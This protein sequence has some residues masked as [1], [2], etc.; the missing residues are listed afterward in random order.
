[1]SISRVFNKWLNKLYKILAILLVVFAVLI[2]SLR[3][4]IPYAHQ[5]R[6]SFQDYINTSYNSN[7]IIGSLN[8]E[9]Q[10]YGPT[11]I[12]ENVN[13]LQTELAEVYIRKIAISI[14]FWAS[15][16]AWE[17]ISYDLNLDGAKVYLDQYVDESDRTDNSKLAIEASLLSNFS[18][19]FLKRISQFSLSN[20]QVIYRTELEEHTFL[21]SQLN[22]NNKENRHLATGDVIV[23]GLSSNNLKLLIDIEGS[24]SQ[25]MNGQIYLQGNELNITPWLDEVFVIE[26]EITHSTINFDAWLSIEDG[27]AKSLQVVL[28]DN[29]ISWQNGDKNQSISMHQGQFFVGGL[30]KSNQLT[31]RST[32]L[33]LKINQDKWQELSIEARKNG[34]EL[35]AYLTYLDLS[36]LKKLFPLFSN[37]EFNSKMVAE[38]ALNGDVKDIYFYKNHQGSKFSATF[39]DVNSQYS[40]GIP[41]LDNVSGSLIYSDNKFQIELAAKDGTLDFDQHFKQALP[42][43]QLSATV[44]AD[45]SERPWRFD[46]TSIS[47]ISDELTLS[48]DIGVKIPENDLV[49]MSLLASV[50]NLNVVNAN[51]YYPYM[52][53]GE[54]LVNYLDGA[55]VKGELSQAQILFHGPLGKFPFKDYSGIFT[56]DAELTDAVFKFASEWPAIN[57]FSANLNFTNNSMLIHGRKGNLSGMRVDGVEA[58]ILELSGDQVLT[59]NVELDE[60]N[61]DHVR[62]LMLSS[63]LADT[64]GKTLTQIAI[65][66]NISGEFNLTLPL[67]SKDGSVAKGFINLNNNNVSLESPQ[68]NFSQVNG[69]LSFNNNVIEVEDLSLHW[70]GLPL[71]VSVKANDEINHY[72]TDITINANWQDDKWHKYVP[73]LLKK[74]VKGTFDWQGDL[75]LY[76]FHDGGFSYDFDV[77]SDLAQTEL[78]F[79]APYTKKQQSTLPLLAKISGQLNQS[80]FNL[81]MGNQLSFYGMLDHG[82]S[83]FT[84]AHLVL[85]DEQMLLPTEGFLITTNLPQ[86]NLLQWQPFVKDIIDSTNTNSNTNEPE[87]TSHSLVVKP[88]RIRGSIGKLDIGSQ[89]LTDVSFDLFDKERWWLLQLNAKEARSQIKFY[90]DWHEEGIEV[91]ADFIHFAK[92]KEKIAENKIAKTANEDVADEIDLEKLKAA[93]VKIRIEN[94]AIFSDIPPVRFQCNSC[95]FSNLD[96][97]KLEFDIVRE[98]TDVLVLKR[99]FAK[100]EKTELSLDGSWIHNSDISKTQVI[101]KLTTKDIGHE[102]EKLGFSS[103]IK[104]SGSKSNIDISWSGGP[105]NFSLANLNGKLSTKLDDGYLADVPDGAR[106]LSV[107]SLQSLVRKLKLDFRDIFA[108][109][110]F[111][112]DITADFNLTDGILY[113]DNIKLNGSAG[114]LLMKGNTQLAKGILD[115][116]LSYKTNLTSNLPALAWIATLNPVTFLAGV[117]L[118]EVITSKVVYEVNFELTGT[119]KTPNIREVN[120]KSKDIRVGQSTPPQIVDSSQKKLQPANQE[121]IKNLTPSDVL[122]N[123]LNDDS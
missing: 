7:I 76:M 66:K 28:G 43:N 121:K 56:V 25:N 2:S 16:A 17:I 26:K 27:L 21:I 11:L 52:L 108:D 115:Y 60:T 88:E 84:K 90:P 64:V 79:P 93:L 23:D 41:G 95:K 106:I 39:S 35:F 36:G 49:Q 80:T 71:V 15:L 45:F 96:L 42:Y 94:D 40:Q 1:M 89:S 5:Y 19:L 50:S 117:A 65:A 82:T 101:G 9:W 114:D 70:Q 123:K 4:F 13:L 102:I 67:K 105:Q 33:Q 98:E 63:P 6:Q 116:R 69:Q 109:G 62:D 55:L 61:P 99:L 48:G 111:Y 37:D 51:H 59:V 110:M 68:L 57:D 46:A 18:E 72:G 31:L 100:R 91:N 118:N 12:V 75:S 81:S 38:L 8:M 22:W 20:S 78:N 30:D 44:S 119:V 113:S 97:G 77:R 73:E 14:D 29:E 107:L 34:D 54:N 92:T 85:G 122:K 53:M 24:N 104:D 10:R 120:R 83:Q 58:Q 86:A 74:Y 112:N 32:P 47:I 103:G 3:L 87:I